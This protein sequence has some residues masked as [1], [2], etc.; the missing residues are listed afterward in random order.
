[1]CTFFEEKDT[2]ILGWPGKSP[3]LNP[4]QNLWAIIKC[5]IEKIKC[6]TV[7]KLIS[8]IIRTWY[9]D[10]EVFKMCSTL[11]DSMPK[12]VKMLIKAKGGHIL[13]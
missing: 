7:Q 13:Y 3:D 12:H 5:R 6:S 4:I 1:M 9:H 10:D 11:V 8:V 2:T